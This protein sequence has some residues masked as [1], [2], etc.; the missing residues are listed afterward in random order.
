MVVT[1]TYDTH[2]H[3]HT[4][5]KH[6]NLIMTNFNSNSF[7]KNIVIFGKNMGKGLKYALSLFFTISVVPC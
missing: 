6:S 4:H 7:T 5:T 3:T 1:K 2:T